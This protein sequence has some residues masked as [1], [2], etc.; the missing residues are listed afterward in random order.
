MADNLL[1]GSQILKIEDG[2][3]QRHIEFL[4]EDEKQEATLKLKY[5]MWLSR[6]FVF[7][8]ILSLTLFWSASLALFRLAPEVKV[9]P[10][11]IISQ[12][13]SN[14]IVRAETI[15]TSMA[16]RDKLTEM[17]VKQYVEAR[18]TIVDDE[19]EMMSR[20]FP[21]GMVNFLSSPK[22]FDAFSQDIDKKIKE[23]LSRGTVQEVEIVATHRV[24]G[25]HSPI[26]KVDFKT[27]TLE[28]DEQDNAT[29]ERVMKT[30]YWTA[31]VTAV[32]I[33]ERAFS[34]IRLINPL[35]FTVL[36]YSQALVEGL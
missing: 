8:A 21:G 10:F 27:Y 33:K 3:A 30:R 24:G 13:N 35:G 19:I 34:G 28:K 4:E 20:W 1:E 6:F 17:Y 15:E 31:S 22:I 29:M 18:N 14:G 16:S 36:R 5:Y 25:Q 9:K 23:Q 7:L 2:N 32:Y 11:L 12:D 26:W